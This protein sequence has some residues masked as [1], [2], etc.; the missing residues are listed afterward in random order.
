M[1]RCQPTPIVG[2]APGPDARP[3]AATRTTTELRAT[4]AQYQ[5]AT[6]APTWPVGRATMAISCGTISFATCRLCAYHQLVADH[7]AIGLQG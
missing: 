1:H 5:G 7:V 6:S 4:H 3:G 2:Q